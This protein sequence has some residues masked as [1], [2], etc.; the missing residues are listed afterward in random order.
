MVASCVMMFVGAGLNETFLRDSKEDSREE[1]GDK[2]G[3]R[4]PL[5]LFANN[6]NNNNKTVWRL[7]TL[8][9][10]PN[11][12]HNGYWDFRGHSCLKGTRVVSIVLGGVNTLNFLLLDF[13][14]I[15]NWG[16]V[17][18]GGGKSLLFIHDLNIWIYISTYGAMMRI[19]Y[20]DYATIKQAIN[21]IDEKYMRW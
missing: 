4:P 8:L 14:S 21:I 16:F 13:P 7:A 20:I 1:L 18:F 6:N 3:L 15:K 11:N 10:L 5:C 17:I 19:I 2:T 12:L 9:R